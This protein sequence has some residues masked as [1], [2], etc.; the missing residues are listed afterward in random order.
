MSTEGVEAGGIFGEYLPDRENDGKTIG[1][2]TRI[3]GK[4]K[5]ETG[6]SST[7]RSKEKKLED[8]IRYNL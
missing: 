3:R 4:K 7:K 2:G 8:R 6:D 1:G 5:K